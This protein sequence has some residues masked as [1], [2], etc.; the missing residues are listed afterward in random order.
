MVSQRA[1]RR[2]ERLANISGHDLLL[3]MMNLQGHLAVWSQTLDG[4][5]RRVAAGPFP[6]HA[7]EAWLYVSA[8]GSALRCI[9]LAQ[10]LGADIAVAQERFAGAVPEA[11]KVRDVLE[12]LEDYELGV[13]DLQK[14][15][16]GS[17]TLG[18]M[19]Q[20]AADT[21]GWRDTLHLQG[22]GLS[23][24]FR[25]TH[26]AVTALLSDSMEALGGWC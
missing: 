14:P 23:L 6:F 19:Y 10:D 12:H 13:G 7:S 1:K 20:R 17:K 2:Q 4:Q 11:K 16:D 21:T 8:L 25:A 26:E 5:S 9:G 22:V 3:R 15:W 18:I 24:D